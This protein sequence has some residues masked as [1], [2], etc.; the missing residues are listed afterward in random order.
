MKT[1]TYFKEGKNRIKWV[2]SNFSDWFGDTSFTPAKNC[3]LD[4][5]VLPR[6][7]NDS[8]IFKE[9]G[10][11][12]V[13][14]ADV[15]YALEHAEEIGLLKNWKS[16]IFYVK[17]KD[18]V[19]RAVYAFWVAGNGWYVNAFEVSNPNAWWDGDR[20]FSR[21]FLKPSDA[22]PDTQFLSPSDPSN[23]ESRVKSL[24]EWK[25]S[26]TKAFL[27]TKEK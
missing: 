18:S 1:S 25:E 22:S 20:I 6:S 7:M 27:I 26:I 23:L 3:K 4:F 8:E 21:K 19:P 17:D 16:N 9:F 12:E 24:E 13:T 14:L 10:P 15:A 5:R 11:E 2:S